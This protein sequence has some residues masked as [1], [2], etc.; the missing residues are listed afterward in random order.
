M[1]DVKN[2]YPFS[3]MPSVEK[4][5]ELEARAIRQEKSG[6]DDAAKKTWNKVEIGEKF[7]REAGLDIY[8]EIS[9]IK[10]KQ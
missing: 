8:H 9:S 4:L 10:A 7:R 3:E 6:F 5:D 1:R 2:Y